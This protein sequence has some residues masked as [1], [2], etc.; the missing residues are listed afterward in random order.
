MNPK[1]PVTSNQQPVATSNQ[2]QIQAG[3]DLFNEHQF[4]HAHEAWEQLWLV[5]QGEEKRFLQGL[6]QLAAAYHHVKRGTMR[7]AV[8]L[9]DAA[10]TKLDSFPDEHLGVH[11]GEAVA[12]SIVH[13]DRIV[14]GVAIDTSEYPKLRYNS[15][16]SSSQRN[17]THRGV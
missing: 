10:L 7:G 9:F 2:Q 15:S 8:R 6:I 13:R 11:R 17:L 1:E 5:A 4:W 12:A 3:I 16:T 14:R